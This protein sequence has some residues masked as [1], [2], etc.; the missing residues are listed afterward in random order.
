MGVF[1]FVTAAALIASPP[2]TIST[3]VTNSRPSSHA[4]DADL[5]KTNELGCRDGEQSFCYVL[6]G[7]S[8]LELVA[9]QTRGAQKIYSRLLAASAMRK[10]AQKCSANDRIPPIA[11]TSRVLAFK[12]FRSLD[13]GEG[14]FDRR[15]K[16]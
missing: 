9:R 14:P 8:G 16:I 4:L 6:A 1:A 3:I 11:H 15:R 13:V 7:C 10:L 5:R 2:T 12:P